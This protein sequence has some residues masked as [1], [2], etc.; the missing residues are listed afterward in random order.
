MDERDFVLFVPR[1]R[2]NGPQPHSAHMTEEARES[3][4]QSEAE[5]PAAPVDEPPQPQPE[6][7]EASSSETQSGT[8]VVEPASTG[9][10]FSGALE[11]ALW[12][13]MQQAEIRRE[14]VRLACIATGRILRHAVAFDP[15]VIDR[16][17]ADALEA[18]QHEN[19]IV[20][21]HP[22]HLAMLA[23]RGSQCRSDERLGPGDVI[24]EL[25]WGSIGATLEERAVFG[26]CAAASD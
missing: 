10:D 16:F 8:P 4:A 26:T 23:D 13:S 11:S 17:V 15:K 9:P 1:L 12:R 3:P 20:R 25:P 22:T 24:V 6:P 2:H 18:A 14:A 19:A 5:V 21:V 7:H